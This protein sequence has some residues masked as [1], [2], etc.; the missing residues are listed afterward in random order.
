MIIISLVYMYDHVI[1]YMIIFD[2]LY[3]KFIFKVFFFKVFSFGHCDVSYLFFLSSFLEI[4]IL[5]VYDQYIIISIDCEIY[6]VEELQACN[7]RKLDVYSKCGFFI[8]QEIFC[9]KFCIKT[10][11]LL[12]KRHLKILSSPLA[13]NE[14]IL[15]DDDKKS[16]RY[17]FTKEKRRVSRFILVRF[18]RN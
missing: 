1:N 7:W 6:S 8:K 17:C 3:L 12:N 5:F 2:D 9:L 15:L 14:E 18:R 13:Y 16:K 4:L 10:I 11:K